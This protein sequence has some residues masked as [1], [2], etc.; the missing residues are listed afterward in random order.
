MITEKDFKK[1]IEL[2]TELAELQNGT[3]LVRYEKQWN[4]TMEEVWDFINKF[5]NKSAPN[6]HDIWGDQN[7]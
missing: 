2:L 7:K 5:T 4:E 3:P 6:I 1:A